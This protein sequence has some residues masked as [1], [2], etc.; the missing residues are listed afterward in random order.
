MADIFLI[1]LVS[2]LAG[3]GVG[4]LACLKWGF[5]EPIIEPQHCPDC[6]KPMVLSLHHCEVCGD[7][8]S[9]HVKRTHEGK[10]RCAMHKN[11]NVTVPAPDVSYTYPPPDAA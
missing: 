10:W 4:W 3:I 5:D 1:V 7:A 8:L 9:R 6:S 11:I 2:V